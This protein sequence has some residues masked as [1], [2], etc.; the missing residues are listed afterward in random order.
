MLR[1]DQAGVVSL[2]ALR[3]IRFLAEAVQ[4]YIVILKFSD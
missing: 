4:L 3:K 2:R 1:L